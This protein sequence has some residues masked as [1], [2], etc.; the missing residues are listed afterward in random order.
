MNFP[1]SPIRSFRKNLHKKLKKQ[2]SVMKQKKWMA[3]LFLN[4]IK[5]KKPLIRGSQS[6]EKVFFS[7]YCICTFSLGRLGSGY[8]SASVFGFKVDG[9]SSRDRRLDQNRFIVN[10][11]NISSSDFNFDDVFY[12]NHR[13]FLIS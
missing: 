3:L 1:R 2:K 10:C 12:T 13:H 7:L 5:L 4:W 11:F 8:C 9:F 6:N